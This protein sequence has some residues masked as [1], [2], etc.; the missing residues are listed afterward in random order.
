V[1]I[2]QI[3]ELAI[4]LLKNR[5][6]IILKNWLRI[7]KK[8]CLTFH[9]IKITQHHKS[10]SSEGLDLKQLLT[11]NQIAQD[12][13]NSPHEQLADSLSEVA[14][15]MRGPG[16]PTPQLQEYVRGVE[17]KLAV[18]ELELAKSKSSEAELASAKKECWALKEEIEA[19]QVQLA[20]ALHS[21]VAMTPELVA[22]QQL[23][24]SQVP[25][26]SDNCYILP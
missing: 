8:V 5:D 17:L 23:L 12:E 21:P 24:Q 14:R 1:I 25:L 7:I 22:Q 19:V 20:G 2:L 9:F 15:F 11:Q 26:I 6:F 10:S 18:V 13:I 3:L 16:R 4:K